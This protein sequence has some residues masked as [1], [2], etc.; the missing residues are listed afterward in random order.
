[1]VLIALVIAPVQS[2]GKTASTVDQ[3][4]CGTQ[5]LYEL[6]FGKDNL[7]KSAD[8]PFYGDCDIPENRDARLCDSASP[9]YY[10]RL[11]FHVFREDDGSNPAGN[12]QTVVDA[13]NILNAYYAPLKIQFVYDWQY[14]NSSKYRDL[15]GW[16]EWYGMKREFAI[17]PYY[18][19]NV[20]ITYEHDTEEPGGHDSWGTFPWYHDDLTSA[21]G[22]I[23]NTHFI[24]N[25]LQGQRILVHE[26]GHCLGLWHNFRGVEEV[27]QCGTCYEYPQAT[28]RDYTGDFCSDTDPMPRETWNCYIPYELSTDPCTGFDWPTS[29]LH[30][31]MSYSKPSCL[32]EIS[33]QQGARMRCWLNS[34]MSSW[35]AFID[36]YAGTVDTDA[37]G[38]A[39]EYDNCVNTPNPF[40][41]DIDLDLIGDACDDCIDSDQDGYGDPDYGNT[42][43]DDNCPD[44]YNPDQTDTD[45]DGIGDACLF[46]EVICDTINTACT[47]LTVGNDGGYAQTIG[48]SMDYSHI[49]DCGS[50][51]IYEG[52]SMIRYSSQIVGDVVA[53]VF[54]LD[55]RIKPISGLNEMIPTQ[56]MGGYEYYETGTMTTEDTLL[57]LEMSWWAPKNEENCRFVIQRKKIFRYSDAACSSIYIGDLIDWDIPESSGNDRSGVDSNYRLIYQFGSGYGCLD[58]SHRFGALSFLGAYTYGGT[59]ETTEPY[60]AHTEPMAD[61][62]IQEEQILDQG[63]LYSFIGQA[64]YSAWYEPYDIFSGMTY[65]AEV[66]LDQE[67]TLYIYTALISLLDGTVDSLYA[68]VEKARYW[69]CD[70]L[71]YCGDYYKIGDANGDGGINIG[72]AVY[73]INHIFNDG[74]APIPN[75]AGDTNCDETVNIGDAVYLINHIFNNGPDPGENCP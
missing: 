42:C 36:D 15:S 63:A 19:C 25:Y 45:Y 55:K 58:N 64:G 57:G 68:N 34:D 39:D 6:K 75:A 13:V 73:L 35:I 47:R 40:Q 67:D 59:I 48:A 37:D 23:H 17:A 72:D 27:P 52:T 62:V 8:C 21:G 43:P 11:Y 41:M 71:G 9:I 31:V 54:K 32:D 10:I 65:V 5:R 7:E 69:V 74:P 3:R 1:M 33:P 60:G 28:D 18:I 2:D 51:Y 50:Y 46:A 14:V 70:N 12:E 61:Y 4:W 30:N 56:V 22:I 49:G 20:Y 24:D 29:G 38:V 53:H 66:N 16:D 44:V 26:M